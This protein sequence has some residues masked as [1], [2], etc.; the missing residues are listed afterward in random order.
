MKLR[1][2]FSGKIPSGPSIKN[3]DARLSIAAGILDTYGGIR[4]VV[5]QADGLANHV[6]HDETAIVVP[7]LTLRE[8]IAWCDIPFVIARIQLTVDQ[9]LERGLP[10]EPYAREAAVMYVLR[11]KELTQRSLDLGAIVET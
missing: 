7:D 1:L 5:T 8:P 3:D 10:N 6:R 9:W 4:F 11:R 2:A